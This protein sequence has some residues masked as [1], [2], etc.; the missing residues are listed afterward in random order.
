M[1]IQRKRAS[2]IVRLRDT[3]A[4]SP[5][6][7]TRTQTWA[8]PYDQLIDKQNSVAAGTNV[9][10]TL[11]PADADTGTLTIVTETAPP[12]S[13]GGTGEPPSTEVEWVELRK[14]L[15]ANAYFAS[16]TSKQISDAKAWVEDT[17]KTKPTGLALELA[18]KLARG[19]TEY[20]IAAPVIRR[21]TNSPT[22]LTSGGAWQRSTPPVSP[23]G[24]WSYLKTA[25]RVS[26]QGL[27]YQRVEEWTG[28]EEWDTDI[29]P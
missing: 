4:T 28:A 6:K 23:G 11:T 1:S 25:D 10:T 20:S 13:D 22:S 17:S 24:S 18:D 2:N 5:D 14:K 7:T 3:V 29:Y 16:L 19:Q 9:S 8:G 21:T 12:G 26:K 27:K 15:E